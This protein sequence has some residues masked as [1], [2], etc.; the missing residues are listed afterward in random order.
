MR[1]PI[2]PRTK[3]RGRVAAR[4]K[5]FENDTVEG[6]EIRPD[7]DYRIIVNSGNDD[8]KLDTPIEQIIAK[9]A[10][11]HPNNSRSRADETSL[12]VGDGGS[13]NQELSSN[14]N[15]DHS[16][17][18]E[19]FQNQELPPISHSPMGAKKWF[20]VIYDHK[21]QLSVIPVFMI[22]YSV[23]INQE[24]PNLVSRNKELL[25]AGGPLFSMCY[26]SAVLIYNKYN[27]RRVDQ[28]SDLNQTSGGLSAE[29]VFASPE[30]NRSTQLVNSQSMTTIVKNPDTGVTS[31]SFQ[32]RLRPVTVQNLFVPPKSANLNT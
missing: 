8:K 23:G 15:I 2:E 32:E 22:V 31:G 11:V 16:E 17:S 1:D 7:S 10:E 9:R 13:E 3:L 6:E 21:F 20:K 29:L 25:I 12:E 18:R 19:Y 5:R 24:N 30:Q 27:S 14:I 28:E 4:I 26:S